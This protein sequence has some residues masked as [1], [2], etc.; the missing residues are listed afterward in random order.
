MFAEGYQQLLDATQG[1]VYSADPDE[2]LAEF[3]AACV[4][5]SSDD[6]AR[7]QLLAQRT[8]PGFEPSPASW[9]IALEFYAFAS[10]LLNAAG[11]EDQEDIDVFSALV[12][13]L[14]HQQIAND[15]GGTRWVARAGQVTEMFLF[16]HRRR[17]HGDPPRRP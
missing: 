12:A 7:H 2:A 14:N 9:A 8:I 17:H 5:F 11:V 3:V 15:P 10:R 6:I 4:Q 13:G 1:R 16:D